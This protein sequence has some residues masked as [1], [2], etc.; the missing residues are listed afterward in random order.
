MLSI[1]SALRGDPLRFDEVDRHVN[2]RS[3]IQKLQKDVDSTFCVG[4]FLNNADEPIERPAGD[5]D[6]L[7]T[8]QARSRFN[9]PI[10]IHPVHQEIHN[11][12][13]NRRWDTVEADDSTYS[14]RP[15]RIG[16]FLR[17]ECQ[18]DEKIIWK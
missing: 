10:S 7:A 2:F 16:K 15:P 1:D 18:S 12:V 3:L 17:E 14:R 5:S 6:F 11:R 13:I 9:D 8:S 4:R